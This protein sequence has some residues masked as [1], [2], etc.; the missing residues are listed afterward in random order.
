M[1]QR[2]P[3]KEILSACNN[4]FFAVRCLAQEHFGRMDAW[5]APLVADIQACLAMHTLRS[6]TVKHPYVKAYGTGWPSDLLTQGLPGF[7]F[8]HVLELCKLPN[9]MLVLSSLHM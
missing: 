9:E 7:E 6:T 2:S 5:H 8:V 3:G 1:I 4:S